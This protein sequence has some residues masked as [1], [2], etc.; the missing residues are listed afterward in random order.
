MSVSGVTENRISTNEDVRAAVGVAEERVT[1]PRVRRTPSGSWEISS[2]T[3]RSL[4]SR[5]LRHQLKSFLAEETPNDEASQ[6]RVLPLVIVETEGD[7]VVLLD[8]YFP[9]KALEDM[10]LVVTSGEPAW[11]SRFMCN[12]E[13][14]F[15]DLR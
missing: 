9:A 14:L 11:E 1:L 13:P 4:D 7:D 6:V 12:G 3:I 5:Q 2:E 10:V 15:W 8:R